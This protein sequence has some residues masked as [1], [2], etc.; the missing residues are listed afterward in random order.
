MCVSQGQP[1]ADLSN[2]DVTLINWFHSVS[3]LLHVYSIL[4]TLQN[5]FCVFMLQT[6]FSVLGLTPHSCDCSSILQIIYL[7]VSKVTIPPERS[8]TFIVVV[9]SQ[10]VELNRNQYP[11]KM[12]TSLM[13][14]FLTCCLVSVYTSSHFF[15]S[16]YKILFKGGV[17]CFF[18]MLVLRINVFELLFV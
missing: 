7:E 10:V 17:V 5:G 1:K 8:N 2:E 11:C 13:C 18:L 4:T 3:K 14:M 6:A 16:L 9:T 15:L 12:L